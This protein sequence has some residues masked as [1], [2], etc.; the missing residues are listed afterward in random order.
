MRRLVLV[1]SLL[2][3]PTAFAAL[4]PAE[5]RV[6]FRQMILTGVQNGQTDLIEMAIAY[7]RTGVDQREAAVAF[8]KEIYQA[9]FSVDPTSSAIIRHRFKHWMEEAVSGEGFEP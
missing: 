3:M 5:Y 7:G 1:L 8:L 2:W 4:T 9:Q 6:H